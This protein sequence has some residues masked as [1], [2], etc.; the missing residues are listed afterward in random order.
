VSTTPGSS[1]LHAT[2]LL[3]GESGVLLRGPSGA[4]KSALALALLATARNNGTFAALVGD[5][6]VYLALRAGRLVARGG[7]DFAGKIERRGRGVI[8][9]VNEPAAVVR[10]IVDLFDRAGPPP[11]RMPAEAEETAQIFGLSLPRLA[12]DPASGPLDQAVVV[13]EALTGRG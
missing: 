4:G 9:V 3:V 5:D 1:A 13:L 12:L 8:S 11:P 6:R 7:A 2:A 10:L